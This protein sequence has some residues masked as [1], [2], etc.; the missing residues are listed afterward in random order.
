MSKHDLRVLMIND[1]EVDLHFPHLEVVHLPQPGG[2]TLNRL[3]RWRQHLH[4]WGDAA[5]PAGEPGNLMDFDLLLVDVRFHIDHTDPDYFGEG[6]LA[7]VTGMEGAPITTNPFGLL[8]ALPVV[9]RRGDSH[10]PFVWT[11]HSGD[12]GS[13][14]NDPVALWAFGM[15]CAMERRPGW[16]QY[17][18]KQRIPEHFAK[19]LG[20]ITVRSPADAVAELMPRYRERLVDSCRR[21]LVQL[22]LDALKAVL[23]RADDANK[24]AEK[25]KVLGAGKLYFY[26]GYESRCLNVRSL[27]AEHDD[28]DP[29]AIV[30][31]ALPFL[32]QLHQAAVKQA[33]LFEQ[34]LEVMDALENA[35]V[36]TISIADLLPK[37]NKYVLGVAVMVCLWLQHFIEGRLL[38]S[39]PLLM[40]LGLWKDGSPPNY[41]TPR[42]YLRGAG[43]EN[44][45]TKMLLG[46]LRV[47][48]LPPPWREIARTYYTEIL[49]W[50]RREDKDNPRPW[51]ACLGEEP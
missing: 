27:V 51:P 17:P 4:L 29:G 18:D 8:H 35:D 3:G 47:E 31:A 19:Q 42:R 36:A 38:T 45:T 7:H 49:G 12:A 6:S 41:Q 46:R 32:R 14:K 16:D 37:Q 40:E 15:L 30:A 44:V 39:D 2:S 11:V 33:E 24:D 34:V 26:A 25:A 50:P 48:P 20:N 5:D 10:M 23:G 22:D 13:V 21:G 43:F 28:G 9:A 1:E